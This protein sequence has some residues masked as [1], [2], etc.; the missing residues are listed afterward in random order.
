M[1][2]LDVADLR[3]TRCEAGRDC[4]EVFHHK[5]MSVAQCIE[6]TVSYMLD[7]TVK[8]AVHE[9]RAVSVTVYGAHATSSAG[10]ETVRGF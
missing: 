3:I 2:E 5:V 8:N 9:A 6:H 7:T 1:S 10:A 4:A